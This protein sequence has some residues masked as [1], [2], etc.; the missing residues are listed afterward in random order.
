MAEKPLALTIVGLLVGL[1][2]VIYL[3][4]PAVLGEGLHSKT[5]IGFFLLQTSAAGWVLGS[6]LQKRGFNR[7]RCHSWSGAVQQVAAGLTVFVP[8]SLVEHL[9]LHIQLRPMMAVAYLVVFGSIVG[10]SAFI[11]SMAKLPVAVASIYTFV[12]P[13]VAVF[14]GWL[15]FRES[16]GI[17]GVIAMLL[18]FSGILVIRRSENSNAQRQLALA[19]EHEI[20]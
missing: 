3:I 14:L 6:L 17:R 7:S 20:G 16:F 15:F 11:Y 1:S 9:P 13:V 10:Y 18:I 2:G 19:A 5:I 8:A 12:N 4:Y